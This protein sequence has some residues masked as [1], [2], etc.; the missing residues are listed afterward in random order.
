MVEPLDEQ[1]LLI[2]QASTALDLRRHESY[3]VGF[4]NVDFRKIQLS[5]LLFNL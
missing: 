2:P 1:F 3:H 4:E 5:L